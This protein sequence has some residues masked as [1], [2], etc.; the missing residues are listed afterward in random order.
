MAEA[1]AHGGAVR[2]GAYLPSLAGTLTTNYAP[3]NTRLGSGTGTLTNPLIISKVGL[4][5]TISQ[6]I[7]DFGRASRVN[8]AGRERAAEEARHARTTEDRVRLAARQAYQRLWRAQALADLPGPRSA[9]Q[10]LLERNEIAIASIELA[11]AM[12][13][14][15]EEPFETAGLPEAGPSPDLEAWR[16]EALRSHPEIAA[17]RHA[18]AAAESIAAAERRALLPSATALIQAGVVPSHAARFPGNQYL[19]AGVVANVPIPFS[20][21]SRATAKEASAQAAAARSGLEEAERRVAANLAMAL[22]ERN[23]AAAKF[24]VARQSGDP[25]ALIEARYE[26]AQRDAVLRFAA[27]R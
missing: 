8:A 6:P 4:G 7:L 22:L 18:L 24:A 11:A 20:S 21:A 19:A 16:A 25:R 2:G 5:V 26:L 1:A 3:D 23:S 27:S 17:R 15:F 10:S 14:N 13:E 12:G 9:L